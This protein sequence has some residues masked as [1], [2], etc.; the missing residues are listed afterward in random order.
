MSARDTSRRALLLVAAGLWVGQRAVAQAL[1]LPTSRHLA[2]EAAQ[3]A[4]RNQPLIVLVSLHGCVFCE[5]VRRSHLVP[6]LTQGQAVVQIDMHS[7]AP[8][9]DFQATA[10]VHEELVRRWRVSVAPTLL[11]FGPA[12]REVAERMEGTYQPDFYGAYLEE[13]LRQARQR[14]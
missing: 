14:L 9:Q 1:V 10:T 7:Q 8:V 11:F 5:R 2:L 3:A 13:R 6:L 12:G 4:Q